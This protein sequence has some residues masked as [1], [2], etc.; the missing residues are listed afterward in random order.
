MI[1]SFLYEFVAHLRFA[2]RTCLGTLIYVSYVK[3]PYFMSRFLSLFF[4]AA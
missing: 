3:V 2:Y 4:K 1:Y